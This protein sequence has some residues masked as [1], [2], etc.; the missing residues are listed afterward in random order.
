MHADSPYYS[1]T[2]RA[3]DTR[4]HPREWEQLGPLEGRSV[5][6]L[7]CHNGVETVAFAQKGART[8]GVDFSSENLAV[9]RRSAQAAGA[10]VEFVEAD[11]HDAVEALEGR[12]FDL[13][14]TGRGSLPYLPEL[15]AWAG[16]VAELLKPGGLVYLMEFHPLLNS[17]GRAGPGDAGQPLELRYDYQ[18]GR[19]AITF[20][21]PHTYAPSRSG[22]TVEGATVSHEWAH[23]IVD[24]LRAMNHAGLAVDLDLLWE[25]DWVDWPRWDGMTQVAPGWWR[26]PDCSVSIP[27]MYAVGARKPTAGSR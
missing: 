14:Y 17:I 11:V 25:T 3:A 13:V 6:H 22:L 1:L 2:E 23:T 12:T 9:A 19:R 5:L 16:V 26:R 10:T 21:T 4:F 7:Q 20:D 18:G 15:R 24:V 27:L 8:T